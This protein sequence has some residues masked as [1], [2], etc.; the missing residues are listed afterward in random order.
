MEEGDRKVKKRSIHTAIVHAGAKTPKSITE[1]KVSPIFASSV[2][3][4]DNLSL[5]DDIREGRKQGFIYARSG[6]PTVMQLEQAISILDGGEGAAAY[7]SG[8]AAISV[9]FLAELKQ[10]DHILAHNVLYGATYA[11]LKNE[12]SKFGVETT[13]VDFNDLD[14]VRQA[15]RRNTKVIFFET[16]CNPTMEVLDIAGIVHIAK[17]AN[18]K[19]YVDNT[20]ASPVI[21]RPLEYGA[22][23]VIYSATKYLNGHSNLL[24]GII[25]SKADFIKKVK[26]VGT[27]YGPAL[28]PFDAWLT[29]RGLR[30]L[31]LRMERQSANALSLANFLVG[32]NK[33]TAV[34]YPGLESSP[35]YG[36]ANRILK[37]GFGGMLSF[38]VYNG[39]KGA[40]V[41]IDS[42]EM[43]EL[44][45]SL[46][47]VATTTSHPGKTSHRLIPLAERERYG[48][49]DDLI[50]VST[51]IEDITDIIQDFEQALAKV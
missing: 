40:R 50:R 51:G 4:F 26:H 38:T 18:A 16:I 22:D 31:G 48:V 9:A 23:V 39:L 21:C 42:L 1:P 45:P 33:I 6:N 5:V 36:I 28:S 27:L 34:H 25:V 43:T 3:S 32:H 11:L 29:L 19:V 35:S 10:G 47:G 24:A 7:A 37:N 2:W 17:D 20:F 46:A 8:M 49:G 12:L 44:V 30:T 15:I 13:F 41:L 14:A